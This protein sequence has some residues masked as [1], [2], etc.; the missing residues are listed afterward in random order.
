[1]PAAAFSGIILANFPNQTSVELDAIDP[2]TGAVTATRT[3]NQGAASIAVNYL[4]ASSVWRSDFNSNFTQVAATG[5]QGSDGGTSAGY[6]DMSGGFTAVTAGSTGY[7]TVLAKQAVGFAPGGDLWYEVSDS[8]A[9]QFAYVNPAVGAASDQM[10][11]G[12]TPYMTEATG[13]E[14]AYVTPSGLPDGVMAAQTTVYL[15]GGT[16]VAQDIGG[17][18]Y[19]IARWNKITSSTP[20][21]PIKGGGDDWMVA[22][23]SRNSFL[24]EDNTKTMLWLNRIQHGVVQTTRILPVTNRTFTSAVV[25]PDGQ[26]VA[27]LLS[28]GTLWTVPVTGG[29]PQQLTG[30]NGSVTQFGGLMTWTR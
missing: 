26:L 21:T 8:G 25:S 28:D 24:T 16:E 30:F 4:D 2:T 17:P 12:T 15:P 6:V 18:G 13:S 22:P 1:M 23:V 5:P 14:R 20:G 9:T 3:F 27:I 10:Y 19:Q 7:S 11:K 29:Q